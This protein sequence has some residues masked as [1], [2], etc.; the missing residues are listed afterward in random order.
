MLNDDIIDILVAIIVCHLD[1]D[2]RTLTIGEQ[3][4]EEFKTK[5]AAGDLNV[6][7][8]YEP[9][10]GVHISVTNSETAEAMHESYDN[11]LH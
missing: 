7:L 2:T 3:V 6:M 4:I 5:K 11:T 10:V 9:S 8:S 1:N